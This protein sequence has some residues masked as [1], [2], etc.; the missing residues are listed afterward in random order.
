MIATIDNM[1]DQHNGRPMVYFH[2]RNVYGQQKLYPAND[3]AEQFAKLL[4]V[5]TFSLNQLN[6]IIALGFGVA[7]A[8]EPAK[9]V[10]K[11]ADGMAVYEGAHL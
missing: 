5:K 10:G 7:Q 2:A 8:I 9:F 3:R 6:Q 1:P 11:D 4:N